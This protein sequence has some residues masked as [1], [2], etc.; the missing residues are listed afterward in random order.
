VAVERELLARPADQDPA[1]T[2]LRFATLFGLAPRMRLDLTVNQFAAE[3]HEQ[4]EL[5]VF[6]EQFW[7]PYV[8]VADAALA[9]RTVLET[10]RDAVAG[11]VFNVGDSDENY[12]KQT[13]VEIVQEEL[14]GNAEVRYV[15]V[16]EDPRD[17]RV[18]FSKFNDAVGFTANRTVRDGV[19]E[20][21]DAVGKGVLGDIAN[22]AYRN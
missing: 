19:R 16:D 21:L 18:S 20:V 4:R 7:R 11:E 9:I 1:V 10:P 22:P 5:E 2:V 12:Q 17:Y 8:H 13:I 6:G 15:H 14:D 3:L